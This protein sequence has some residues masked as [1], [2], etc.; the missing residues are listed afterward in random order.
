MLEALADHPHADWLGE[1]YAK[2][3]RD[4]VEYDSYQWPE[5]LLDQHAVRLA[6]ILGRLREGPEMARSLHHPYSH[7]EQRLESGP[8]RAAI[9]KDQRAALETLLRLA[10]ASKEPTRK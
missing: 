10:G 4:R 5:E 8:G 2:R 7:I 9:P 1:L 3:F 6:A